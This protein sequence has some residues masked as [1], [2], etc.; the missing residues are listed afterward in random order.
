MALLLL[1]RVLL[2]VI[3]PFVDAQIEEEIMDCPDRVKT[4]FN[5]L[6]SDRLFKA[7]R[8]VESNG[9]QCKIDGNKIGPYQISEQYYNEALENNPMLRDG[10]M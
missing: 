3:V 7:M 1:L 4:L 5:S 10:G 8:L 2:L 6:G 9:N